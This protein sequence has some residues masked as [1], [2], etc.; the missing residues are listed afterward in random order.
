MKKF[1]IVGQGIAGTMLA[2]SLQRR[3]AA[4]HLA[5]GALPG[6]SSIAAAGVIN[7]VTGRRFVRSW[8]FAEFYPVARSAYRALE[9]ELGISIWTDLSI[10]RLLATPEEANDWSARCAL[11]GYADFLSVPAD[12]GHWAPVVKPGFHYG[13]IQPAA[14]VNF[15][16]LLPAFRQK[17]RAEGCFFEK[18]I[19]YREIPQLSAAYDG[20]IFCEGWRARENPFFPD[21]SWQTAKGE[22]LL[23]RLA[24]PRPA[25]GDQILKKTVTL[26]PLGDGLLWVGGAYQWNYT[27]L[28]PG[29]SEKQSILEQL[30]EVL[31][32][33]FDI[34]GQ[35][36]GIRPTVKDR[37]PFVGES[38]VQPGVFLFNGLGSKGA[39]LAP[40]WAEHLAEHMLDGKPLDREVDIRRW[41]S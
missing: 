29:D 32:V 18:Q 11:P 16:V 28:T 3:G 4:V 6:R 25:D 13:R 5:D 12:A 23:I 33:P 9:T 22:A 26:V 39:L 7:P 19:D 34:A 2:W 20:I 40:F 36:A 37:R 1:L 30:K 35:V 21:L 38:R 27:E 10:L 31:A 17:A 8:R 41:E 15:S 14:R 24:D